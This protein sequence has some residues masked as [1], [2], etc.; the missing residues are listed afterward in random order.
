MYLHLAEEVSS[1]DC[2]DR[3]SFDHIPLVDGKLLSNI[4]LF[5]AFKS[6]FEAKIEGFLFLFKDLQTLFADK[7][8]RGKFRSSEQPNL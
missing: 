7:G 6:C 5:I 2:Q 3:S 1:I 8:A 4:F